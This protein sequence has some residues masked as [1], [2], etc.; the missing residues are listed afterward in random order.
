MLKPEERARVHRLFADLLALSEDQGRL[1]AD[2]LKSE[3]PELLGAQHS[4]PP[5]LVPVLVDLALCE[6]CR[7][8]AG[9]VVWTRRLQP[10]GYDAGAPERS[11]EFLAGEGDAVDCRSCGARGRARFVDDE[12]LAVDIDWPKASD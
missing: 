10:D 12:H 5:G 7:G 1:F 2:L 3:A 8:D 11:Y 6:C 9:V 4:P